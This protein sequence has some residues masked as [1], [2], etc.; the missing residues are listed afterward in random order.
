MVR[1]IWRFIYFPKKSHIFWGLCPKKIWLYSGKKSSYSSDIHAINVF[2]WFYKKRWFLI[3]VCFF[4]NNNV[5]IFFYLLCNCLSLL[6]WIVITERGVGFVDIENIWSK[7]FWSNHI[8]LHRIFISAFSFLWKGKSRDFRK[9]GIWY[10][11]LWKHDFFVLY[12]T[13]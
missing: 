5:A 6:L 11:F 1:K 2:L 4:K 12:V 8:C 3:I 10:L 9:V 13:I 7:Y